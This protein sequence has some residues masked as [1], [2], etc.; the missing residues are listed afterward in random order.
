MA[1]DLR[2]PRILCLDGG[3]IRGLSEILILKELMLQVQLRNNLDSVPEPRQCFDFI[4]G[5]STGGLIAILLGRAGKTLDECEQL[6]RELG[7]TIFTGG[8]TVTAARLVLKG[9]KYPIKELGGVIRGQTGEEKMYEDD[10]ARSQ[11]GHIPV[12]QIISLN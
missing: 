8:S 12:R 9:S 2:E 11:K 6:F 3:G 10:S 1:G 4:C 7:S 5:T